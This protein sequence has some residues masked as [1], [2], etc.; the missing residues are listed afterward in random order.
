MAEIWDVEV[1]MWSLKRGVHKKSLTGSNRRHRS[2]IVKDVFYFKKG[3][4]DIDTPVILVDDVL[5]TGATLRACRKLLE[6]NGRTV[7]GAS[8]LALA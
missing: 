1:D 3:C 8:V 4:V 5:T 2:K 6:E 7:L